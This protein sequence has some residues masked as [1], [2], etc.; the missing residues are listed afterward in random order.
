MRVGFIGL[1]NLGLPLAVST[2]RAGHRTKG[3]DIDGD[4][5]EIFLEHGGVAA[6]SVA[7]AAR[8][9]EV[10]VTGLPDAADVESVA[11]GRGNFLD[12]MAVRSVYVDMSTIDPHSMRRIGSAFEEMGMEMIDAPVARTLE[13]AWAGK[14]LLMVGGNPAAIERARPVLDAV[15]ELVIHCG[16]LG[17][18][19]ATKLINNFLANGILAVAVEA[20]GIGLKSGL[21]LETI[22]E[23]VRL[24]GTFNKMMLEN[25]PAHAFRGEFEP[26]FRSVLAHKDQRL[27]FQLAEAHGIHA[28]LGTATLEVLSELVA[29]HP[30]L[31]LSAMLKQ[32]EMQAGF[33]ARFA[34]SEQS[35]GNVARRNPSCG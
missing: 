9:G 16:P 32:P 35:G 12:S 17:N 31:D 24:T 2:V 33:S 34:A 30:D 13:M 10:V 8:Y 21:S 3:F 23:T 25:L 26:G 5:L 11:L 28:P 22:L 27:A 20:L 4:R 1:G 19:A 6:N 18:G 29:A 7:D 14:S 15:S